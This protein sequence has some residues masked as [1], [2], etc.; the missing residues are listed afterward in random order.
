MSSVLDRLSRPIDP[1]FVLTKEVECKDGTTWTM[2]H[3]QHTTVI[4][5]FN[6]A[7]TPLGWQH[8][9]EY[10]PSGVRC[11]IAVKDEDGKW[12][13]HAGRLAMYEKAGERSDFVTE[14]PDAEALKTAAYVWG[15]GLELYT[16]GLVTRYT[17]DPD[18]MDRK[19]KE[20]ERTVGANWQKANPGQSDNPFS[21]EVLVAK[22]AEL[23]TQVLDAE[24]I[25]VPDGEVDQIAKMARRAGWLDRAIKTYVDL[26]RELFLSSKGVKHVAED[27]SVEKSEPLVCPPSN[28][29]EQSAAAKSG[30]TKK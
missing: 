13:E 12:I 4:N 15:V 18:A 21:Y 27:D 23:A 17:S 9:Y 3:I 22:I 14:H 6:E 1:W 5:R 26:Q 19:L 25:I 20:V 29:A 28:P 2:R 10:T 24:D 8:R 11:Y 16:D 7:V 30:K